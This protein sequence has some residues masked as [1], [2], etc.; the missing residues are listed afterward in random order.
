MQEEHSIEIAS[1]QSLAQKRHRQGT[2]D[3][4]G[5]QVECHRLRSTSVRAQQITRDDV[6]LLGTG[7]SCLSGTRS[8]HDVR[9]LLERAPCKKRTQMRLPLR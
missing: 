3:P 2:E 9:T 4:F 5:K 1:S 8:S 6:A 7:Q